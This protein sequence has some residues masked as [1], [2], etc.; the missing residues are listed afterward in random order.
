M[1]RVGEI[2]DFREA[3]AAEMRDQGSI[4]TEYVAS[5][6]NLADVFTKCMPTYKFKRMIQQI[7]NKADGV[8]AEESFVSY[9]IHEY[10]E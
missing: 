3:W 1:S 5:E 9:L 8:G 2:F 6:M 7:Q 10:E 4:D